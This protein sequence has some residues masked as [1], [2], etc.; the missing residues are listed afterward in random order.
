VALPASEDF[1]GSDNP[2][3]GNWTSCPAGNFWNGDGINEVGG[4]GRAGTQDTQVGSYWSADSFNADQYAEVDVLCTASY[5]FG[6]VILRLATSGNTGDCYA[7]YGSRGTRLYVV[8]VDDSAGTATSVTGGAYITVT[9][10]SGNTIRA[11]IEG[12]DAGTIK[13][14]IEDTQ[15]GTD[16]TDS[17]CDAGS[18]GVYGYSYGNITTDLIDNFAAG[19]MAAAGISITVSD[20]LSTMYA[21]SPAITLNSNTSQSGYRWRNDD[22]AEDT[23]TWLADQDVASSIPLDT[24]VRLRIGVDTDIDTDP[25]LFQLEYRRQGETQWR[26]AYYGTGALIMESG[27][28]II[29]EEE[30]VI[31]KE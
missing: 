4:V 15:Q 10:S 16:Y 19:N 28:M 3:T 14:Y 12:V 22:G 1:A 17:D 21:S 27:E 23:A 8:Y 24:T 13:V 26:K 6:G 18:A 7:I 11:T 2:L 29:T 30:E 20:T 9:Y 5:F 31:H 25:M